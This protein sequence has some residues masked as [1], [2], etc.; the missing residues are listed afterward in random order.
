MDDPGEPT[1]SGLSVR[2]RKN[3]PLEISS[4][5]P[6]AFAPA[7][8]IG[9]KRRRY[10]DPRFDEKCGTISKAAERDYK[11]V[12]DIRQR[13]LDS[14]R[15]EYKKEQDPDRKARMNDLLTRLENQERSRTQKKKKEE[16]QAERNVLQKEHVAKGKK[17]FYLKKSDRSILEMVSKFQELKKT[18]KLQQY[19][20]KRRKRNARA[21]A[22]NLPE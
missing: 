20:E 11:F 6:P 7:L 4:K 13:E 15:K 21:D 10:R 14:I 9:V 12:G 18:G 22:R 5:K 1:T 16:K 19:V 3:A 2:Q 8:P 17:P